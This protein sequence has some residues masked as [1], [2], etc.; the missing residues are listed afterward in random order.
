[1]SK[2]VGVSVL[3]EQPM[4]PVASMLYAWPQP[5]GICSAFLTQRDQA[6]PH[7]QPGVVASVCGVCMCVMYMPAAVPAADTLNNMPI[8]RKPVLIINIP[9]AAAAE[10]QLP[11]SQRSQGIAPF[12]GQK[13]SIPFTLPSCRLGGLLNTPRQVMRFGTAGKPFAVHQLTTRAGHSRCWLCL[14]L[15]CS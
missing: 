9:G 13:V 11:Y 6:P 2:S 8:T 5:V 1:M 7:T 3:H 14:C 12:M 15:L 10:P 4:H